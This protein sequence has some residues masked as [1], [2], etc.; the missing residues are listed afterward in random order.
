MAAACERQ[1]GP[2]A[3][4]RR[5]A[6]HELAT[7]FRD[8]RDLGR[9]LA[10]LR[11]GIGLA[12]RWGARDQGPHELPSCTIREDLIHDL[13]QLE[14][15]RAIG[16]ARVA[17][18]DAR[19]DEQ[20]AIVAPRDEVELVIAAVHRRRVDPD[21]ERGVARVEHRR[22]L[23]DLDREPPRLQRGACLDGRVTEQLDTQR[24]D[25]TSR[26]L[27]S[28]GSKNDDAWFDRGGVAADRE[29]GRDEA[30]QRDRAR[31]HQRW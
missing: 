21:D 1:S 20:R 17:R 30:G 12:S 27:V 18:W 22:R 6:R 26:R 9:W 10:A 31:L 2:H 29:G 19:D 16:L 15:E 5:A 11:A 23:G 4:G 7:H 28:F 8:E 14:R 13:A 3:A 25:E 24:I